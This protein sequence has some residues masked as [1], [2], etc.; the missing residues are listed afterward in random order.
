MN[1]KNATPVVSIVNHLKVRGDIMA[2]K[3]TQKELVLKYLKDFGSISTFQA[4]TDLGIT[5]LSGRIFDLKKD[6]YS[7][8]KERV[9][10]KNRYGRPSHYD[11]YSLVEV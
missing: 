2:E 10:I 11:I 7:F 8:K 9:Y 4:F 5:R 3:L 6:G 1:G